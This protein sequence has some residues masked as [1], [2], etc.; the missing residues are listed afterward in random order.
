MIKKTPKR[1]TKRWKELARIYAAFCRFG[2]T[3]LNFDLS[4]KALLAQ[5]NVESNGGQSLIDGIFVAKD[6]SVNGYAYGQHN[7]ELHI[8]DWGDGIEKGDITKGELYADLEQNKHLLRILPYIKSRL[9]HRLARP[10]AA[11]MRADLLRR[12]WR[13][14]QKQGWLR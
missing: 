2:Q 13:N 6:E 8:T 9:A 1:A 5:M 11:E 3:R 4:R 14:W 12:E 10:E 7:L